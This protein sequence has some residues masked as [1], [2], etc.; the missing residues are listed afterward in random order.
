MN[1]NDR[2]IYAL[3][4]FDGVHLGHQALLAAC[5]EL[6]ARHGCNAGA[7]TFTSHPDALVTGHA[8]ELINTIEDRKTLLAA[9]GMDTVVALPFDK[10]LM[11]TH[12]SAFLKQLVD[13]GAAGFICGSDFRFGAGGCGTAK[14]LAAFCESRSQPY[15]IVP[16]QE[17]DGIRVSSTHI[18][19]L[20]IQGDMAQANRFLGHPH[21][22]TGQVV[23]GRGLGHTME[24]PTANLLLPDALVT[25]KLGVYACRAMVDD[26]EYLAVTNI[27]SRP[28]V[29]GHQ[30]RAESWLLDFDG[31]LYGKEIT[32]VFYAYLRP[33][34][35]FSNLEE[36][37]EEI[38]KNAART[39]KLLENP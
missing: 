9:Y 34:K 1:T 12:W 33:E 15:A 18:R 4:V 32:L 6:A 23:P 8:P 26:E 28:T 27:G 10:Q 25:P 19:T 21:V 35:K 16:Q 14:K 29:G 38:L 2:T 24:I 22:L 11:T 37:R 5:R 7:V 31:D 17:L 30:V 20:L 39:R 3:G 13:S 36:L